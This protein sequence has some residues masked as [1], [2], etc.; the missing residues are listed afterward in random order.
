MY[1]KY[2]TNPSAAIDWK[3]VVQVE[4]TPSSALDQ[5]ATDDLLTCPICR[6]GHKDLIAP[7]ITKCGHIYCWPC[8]LQ[9]LD[10]DSERTWKKCPLCAEQ[11]YRHEL[12]KASILEPPS[13]VHKTSE[14]LKTQKDK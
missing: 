9:Y 11:V 2:L 6:E 3:D 14:E 10:Y 7:R 8:I 12:R 13:S 1:F 5:N 4:Y